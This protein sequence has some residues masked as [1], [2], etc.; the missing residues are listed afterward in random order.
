[1]L[2][3]VDQLKLNVPLSRVLWVGIS[4]L[5]I[6]VNLLVKNRG[7]F[8]LTTVSAS[9]KKDDP[10]ALST[11]SNW[12]QNAMTAAYAGA[13]RVHF[14]S[15][16]PPNHFSLGVQTKRRLLVVIN[17]HGGPVSS[18]PFIVSLDLTSLALG[19]SSFTFQG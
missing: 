16:S 3:S 18:V 14:I 12:V 7:S 17:P 8:K 6:N 10:N 11:A 2:H 4:G 5:V 13:I 9:F 19:K 15:H 1:L